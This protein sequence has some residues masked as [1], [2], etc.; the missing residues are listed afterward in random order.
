MLPTFNVHCKHSNC[1]NL[2]LTHNLMFRHCLCMMA[3][4]PPVASLSLST[5]C[6]YTF[7]EDVLEGFEIAH[8][9]DST[10]NEVN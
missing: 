3:T 10:L 6:I 8:P 7:H 4:P 9:E 1:V 2:T 5:W